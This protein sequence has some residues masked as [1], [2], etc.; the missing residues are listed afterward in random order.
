LRIQPGDGLRGGSHHWRDRARYRPA[1]RRGG[2]LAGPP[3][4]GMRATAAGANATQLFGSLV[5]E[6]GVSS[7]N[8][9]GTTIDP[10][11]PRQKQVNSARWAQIL[12]K[13]RR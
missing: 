8:R 12:S 1:G 7:H 11:T 9:L 10:V 3:I 4:P 5:E 13:E 6:D 2:A